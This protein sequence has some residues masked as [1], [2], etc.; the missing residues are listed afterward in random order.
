MDLFQKKW[1]GGFIC[2]IVVGVLGTLIIDSL[3]FSNLI[4]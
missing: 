1:L 4:K 2:G 3:W